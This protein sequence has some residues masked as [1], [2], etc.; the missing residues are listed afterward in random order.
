MD[1]KA[2]L[3]HIEAAAVRGWPAPE[4]VDVDSWLWRHASGGS[5]RA[6]SV[7][8]LAYSGSDLD[9]SISRI[10]ALAT[11]RDVPACF[12]ISDVS[13]PADLDARLA[14]RGYIRDAD[15]VTMA[16]RV[17]PEAPRPAEVDVATAPSPGWLEAYLS[18][19]S[20][21][22][23]PVAPEILKRLP[24][25]ALYISARGHGRVISSGLTIPDRTVA[26]VQCMATLPDAQRQGGAARILEAI[27]HCAAQ[28]GQ[29]ALYLQTGDD[30]DGAQALYIRAGFAIIGRYHTRTKMR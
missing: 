27:E 8:T 28:A 3:P 10:E 25:Q 6:N 19:L 12:A 24:A 29:A 13:V 9:A 26:S 2:L 21:D 20:A 1:L 4:A 18:G 14:A 22:R 15:H 30:N 5:I 16:K 17:S 11:S 23:R 7:A